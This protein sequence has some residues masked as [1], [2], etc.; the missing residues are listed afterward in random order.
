M[1][2]GLVFTALRMSNGWQTTCNTKLCLAPPAPSVVVAAV[3]E[4]EEE[5]EVNLG[6]CCTQCLRTMVPPRVDLPLLLA[7]PVR[8][9]TGKGEEE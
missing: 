2:A 9:W 5:E 7:A 3:G 4:E 1:V 6:R 8:W